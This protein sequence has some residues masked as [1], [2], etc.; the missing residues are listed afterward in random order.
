MYK[1]EPVSVELI[2]NISSTI[3]SG[4]AAGIDGIV[5]ENIK[6]SHPLVMIILSKLFNL[7][8]LSGHVPNEFGL[9]LTIPIPKTDS[10]ANF[11]KVNDFRGIT[12]S[13]VTSKIFEH[14]LQI[15]FDKYLFSSLNQFGFNRGAS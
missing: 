10:K 15:R 9:G 11:V 6:Y 3:K 2:D 8:I 5:S 12:I 14:C 1:I 4:K 7:M 13:P